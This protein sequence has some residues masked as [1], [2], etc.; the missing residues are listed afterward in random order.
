MDENNNV[1][2]E[3][4]LREFG[5]SLLDSAGEGI[6]KGI[7]NHKEEAYSQGI[8][9]GIGKTIAALYDADIEDE[10]IL[11]LMNKHWGLNMNDATDML[12]NEK[13][14]AVIRE[15]RQYFKL[16]GY[17]DSDIKF[18]M[19]ENRVEFKIRRNPELLNLKDNPKK[20][21]EAIKESH[22]NK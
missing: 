17:S 14:E 13:G 10:K 1:N 4:K 3:N 11:E 8:E 15:L 16:Q 21:I 22:S 9:V 12:I 20:V 18:F 2:R 5:E 7:N 6:R 19:R